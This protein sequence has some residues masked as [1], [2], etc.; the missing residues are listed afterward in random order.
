MFLKRIPHKSVRRRRVRDRLLLALRVIA[1]ALLAA[2]FARPFV[3]RVPAAGTALTPARD[4][5]LLVDR[6][7]SMGY[8]DRFARALDQ[9]GRVIAGLRR[10]DRAAVVFF[11]ERASVA[12]EQTGDA[13]VLRAALDSARAG[14]HRTRYAPA[15]RTAQALL[16]ASERPAREVVLISDFQQ[17]G[18]EADAATRLPEGVTLTT[19]PITDD[20]TTNTLVAGVVLARERFEARERVRVT[21]RLAHRGTASRAAEVSLEIAGRVVQTQ[22]AALDAAGVTEIVFAPVTLEQAPQRAAVRI[23][24]DALPIDDVHYFTI[25]PLRPVRVLLVDGRGA[26]APSSLFLR[27]ALAIGEAPAFA[28]RSTTAPGA[29]ELAVS[30]IVLLNGV[31]WP[32]GSAGARLNDFVE[33]GGAVIAILGATGSVP[34]GIA[35]V[36]PPIDRA[37][38]GGGAIGFVEYAHPALELFREPRN[39]DLAG[40]RF[41]RYRGV[42]IAEGTRVLARYDDG[43]PALLEATRGRG[44]VVIFTSTLDTYWTT[45]PLQPVFLPLL[46]ALA[47]H[48]ARWNPEPPALTIGGVIAL[49]DSAARTIL[50]PAG[51]PVALP[52]GAD[53]LRVEEPGFYELRDAAGQAVERTVAVNVDRTESDL[54]AFA[55]ATLAAA[56][57]PAGAPSGPALAGTLLT[58]EERERRQ[59]LWWYV[60]AAAIALLAL[61]AVLAT[62]AARA[63]REARNS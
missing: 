5:V 61:E 39:G 62:R 48:A 1:L 27:Q 36:R 4:V 51:Q 15:L 11:D 16:D 10:D 17:A 52:D 38:G 60:L 44:S 45:L 31:P 42:E 12:T 54:S 22:R 41:Y 7:Y 34:D 53:V 2:A 55:P 35:R 28:V 8:G 57:A 63:P 32:G 6:S 23:D 50:S 18:W 59:S 46:H 37:S 29:G 25:R 24:A 20:A 9:A 47:A 3:E 30:D 49:G 19:I 21:A 40:A 33:R 43:H 58:I 14:P 56:V 26:G 13:A